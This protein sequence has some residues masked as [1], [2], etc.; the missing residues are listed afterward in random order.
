MSDILTKYVYTPVVDP[1][2]EITDAQQITINLGSEIKNNSMRMV[3]KNPPI[4]V[5]AD[6]T[7]R[8][9]W[10]DDEKK[11]RFKVIKAT[12]KD[13]IPDEFIDIYAKYT[14]DDPTED[15]E[16]TDNLLFTGVINQ[17]KAVFKNNKH[18]LELRGPDRSKII[19][20]R[21]SDPQPYKKT[22]SINTA[23]KII[24][25]IVRNATLAKEDGATAFND[26]G[27][28][29]TTGTYLVDARLF[30]ESILDS[31]TAT[32]S[33][34]RV[35]YGVGQN[36]LTT[37]EKGDW[38]RNMSTDEYAY[39]VSVETDDTLKLSKDILNNTNDYEISD[40]FIQDIRPNGTSAVTISFSQ[41]KKPVTEGITEL[42]QISNTN[43]VAEADPDD[44]SAS[45]VIKRGM[46][47]F[48]DK[49][50][51]LHWYVPSDSPEHVMKVGQ[52]AAISP[53]TVYHRI[54]D[55]DL[56]NEVEDNINFIVYRSGIDMSANMVNSYERA[57]FSG[58]PNAKDALRNWL[59]IARDM[60]QEEIDA[61]NIKITEGTYEYD[62]A[63]PFAPVWDSQ[64][65]TANNP[66][67]Y[68]SYFRDE[69]IKRGDARAQAVFQK[70]ANPR[71][72]GKI[73]IRG[74]DI[75]VGDLVQFTSDELG[76]Q[77]IKMRVNGVTHIITPEQGWITSINLEE[78]ENEAEN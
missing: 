14:E 52:T 37:V 46:R 8:H 11:C 54:H 68:N 49:N 69:A 13:I 76:I 17:G 74:E 10:I 50:N 31:G 48:I 4:N 36:F 71:W 21:L 55:V 34:T 77:D 58:T 7:I 6:G 27:V 60:K 22:G 1:V 29:S 5:F 45:L 61:G 12:R 32:A 42:S 33:A 56:T 65:R 25:D 66:K 38:V 44:S 41:L 30:T 26:S 28:S 51:R 47:W 23:P 70:L 78:D 63:F 73:Q 75:I 53:D 20:D 24:Q 18:S 2:T 35:L 67:E 72:K 57:K 19:L 59:S 43:T 62:T 39:V 3:L 15:V 40:G 64:Q 16:N 9:K